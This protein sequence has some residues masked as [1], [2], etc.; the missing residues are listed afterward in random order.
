MRFLSI[1]IRSYH[2]LR[3][4]YEKFSTDPVV[5][6]N[7]HRRMIIFWMLNWIPMNIVVGTAIWA[8]LSNHVWL[9]V[10]MSAIIL[11]IN[12]NYSLY[13]N[14]D[15]EVGDAHGAY[16]SIRANEIRKY[17]LRNEVV[18]TPSAGA[19]DVEIPEADF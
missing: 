2:V 14:W 17:Q 4:D 15:T 6:Y 18:R 12:T 16:A 8:S 1:W 5:Q 9:A 13:A 19:A 7:Y 3:R 11:G 10:L